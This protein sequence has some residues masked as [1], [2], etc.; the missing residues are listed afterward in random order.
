MHPL[1][2]GSGAWKEAAEF[3]VSTKPA[4]TA[5][6]GGNQHPCYRRAT[7]RGNTDGELLAT[8]GRAVLQITTDQPAIP[9]IP[10]CATLSSRRAAIY[11]RDMILR[12]PFKSTLCTRFD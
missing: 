3:G 2:I 7:T 9:R 5:A 6:M 4:G 1:R 10:K 12:G 8:N 11:P